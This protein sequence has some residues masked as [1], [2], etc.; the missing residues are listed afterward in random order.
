MGYT[1]TVNEKIQILGDLIRQHR[2][3]PEVRQRAI[4]ILRG[5]GVAPKDQLGEINALYG[6]VRD[7][8]RFTYD[9]AYQD[10]FT[11]PVHTL[12]IGGGDC[13]CQ[14][15]LLGSLL[16]SVGHPVSI[17]AVGFNPDRFSHVYLVAQ[18]GRLPLDPTLGTQIPAGFELPYYMAKVYAVPP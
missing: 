4:A 15:A 16:E 14:V 9:P 6:W 8:I 13:D 18:E 11:S 17:K 1:V 7:N 12:R 3:H 2:V 5:A 10:V